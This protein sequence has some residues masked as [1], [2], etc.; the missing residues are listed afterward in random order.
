MRSC[1]QA[2]GSILLTCHHHRM[3]RSAVECIACLPG[4]LVRVPT[5]MC[6]CAGMGSPLTHAH[7][8]RSFHPCSCIT[9]TVTPPT[10]AVHPALA[11]TAAASPE[12]CAPGHMQDLGT[13]CLLPIR[14][15]GDPPPCVGCHF[16]LHNGSGNA[17][18]A[19]QVPSFPFARSHTKCSSSRPSR[20][21]GS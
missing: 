14:H 15:L 2:V 6:C 12:Q 11:A 7:T 8:P 20:M 13:W 5:R 21:P 18:L 16:S 3:V 17:Y 4:T 1:L 10:G 19:S 9:A